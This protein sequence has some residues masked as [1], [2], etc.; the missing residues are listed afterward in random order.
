M[1]IF[2]KKWVKTNCTQNVFYPIAIFLNILASCVFLSIIGFSFVDIS[3]AKISACLLI[4]ICLFYTIVSMLVIICIGFYCSLIDN[5]RLDD[6]NKNYHIDKQIIAFFV[7][8]KVP[9]IVKII[10][11]ACFIFVIK[12]WFLVLFVGIYL[13][14]VFVCNYVLK[15]LCF[16]FVQ[17][18]VNP[19]TVAIT[20]GI[21]YEDEEEYV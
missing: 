8:Y 6:L 9:L 11:I 1:N 13:A 17:K 18:Y 19:V 3:L 4:P 20:E 14:D 15:F 21:S 7:N 10:Y 12:D 16:K 5:L 2:Q